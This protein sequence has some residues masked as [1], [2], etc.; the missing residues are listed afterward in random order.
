MWVARAHPLAILL[1]VFLL[2][3]SVCVCVYIEGMADRSKS[4]LRKRQEGIVSRMKNLVLEKKT[5]SQPSTTVLSTLPPQTLDNSGALDLTPSNDRGATRKAAITR[6]RAL[7]RQRT[8][9]SLLNLSDDE[10]DLTNMTEE[11]RA[12]RE[13]R[14]LAAATA[15]AR[16]L[17]GSAIARRP[18][19]S[20]RTEGLELLSDG[21]EELMEVSGSLANVDRQVGRWAYF[22][23]FAQPSPKP[24]T[25]PLGLCSQLFPIRNL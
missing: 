4:D 17:R 9:G 5:L 18:I 15:A 14:I 3:A 16:K 23:P 25:Q 6:G 7:P 21:E 10:E 24:Y 12:E 8:H 22:T 2:S 1:A 11:E 20:R 13:E 19:H